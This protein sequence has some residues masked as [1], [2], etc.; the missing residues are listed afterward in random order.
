MPKKSKKGKAAKG[1]KESKSKNVE[2]KKDAIL[3]DA[4]A[5]ALFWES[6]LESSE[7]IKKEYRDNAKKLLVE[8]ETLQTKLTQAEKDTV[9]VISFLKDEDIKKQEQIVKSEQQFK[10]CKKNLTSQ[11]DKLI[12]KYT[13]QISEL[14]EALD[15]KNN[16]VR[17]IQSELRLVKEFRKKRAQMQ[18]ELDEIKDNMFTNEKTHKSI[19]GN[20]EQKFFEEK[21]RLQHESNRKIAE[22]A[23]RAH[24]EAVNNLDETTRSV[25]KENIRVNAA[26]EYH[27][28]ESKGL[29]KRKEHLEV[30]KREL[31]NDN[32]LNGIIVQ[33]KVIE[34]QHHKKIMKELQE[35]VETLEKS[36]S[37]VIRE[38]EVERMAIVQKSGDDNKHALAEIARLTKVVEL[39]TKEM[40]RVKRLAKN[41]LDQRSEIE[42]FFLD[43]LECV[44]NEIAKNRS[45]YRKDA[46]AAYQER[47]LAAHSGR[48]DY[49]KIRTFNQWNTS[50]NSVFNDLKEAETWTGLED[51]VDISDLTWEQRE[52]VL[53][54]LFAKLNGHKSKHRRSIRPL[55]G[56]SESKLCIRDESKKSSSFLPEQHAADATF[57]T[58]Q[59]LFATRLDSNELPAVAR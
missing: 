20:M 54:L 27:M 59:P 22:L 32:E 37:H 6:K 17:L 29:K 31:E 39:K 16:E 45:H 48:G 52:R 28:S 11:K 21:I 51:K 14:E 3:K 50:T 56:G 41:I 2:A 10:E 15:E 36:L 5:N 18:R 58:Q 53:R 7:R 38:F 55:E 19:L 23:E 4:T 1:Q 47:M 35:K 57:I 30:E 24:S 9:Q 26:L 8:N 40:N 12:E 33:E 46:Q 42:H 49:P 25:Y 34:S 43:S 13:Q 44:K